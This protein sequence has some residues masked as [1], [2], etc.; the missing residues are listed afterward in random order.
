MH[1][2]QVT[3]LSRWCSSC[4]GYVSLHY[5]RC[6][7]C[8]VGCSLSLLIKLVCWEVNRVCLQHLVAQRCSNLCKWLPNLLRHTTLSLSNDDVQSIKM[9]LRHEDMYSSKELWRSTVSHILCFLKNR[10]WITFILS[11]CIFVHLVFSPTYAL[12]YIIKILSQAVTLIAHFTPTCFDPFGSSSG[13]T[14]GP[15]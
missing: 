2:G 14:A 11:P 9:C 5:W 1:N 8:L 4:N 6:L 7:G 12:I 15:S 3:N 13:S 10:T